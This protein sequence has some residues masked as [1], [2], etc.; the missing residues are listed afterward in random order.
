[1]RGRQRE[2]QGWKRSTP[3]QILY[4]GLRPACCIAPVDD[5]AALMKLCA[6]LTHG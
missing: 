5:D 4:S 1:M 6:P 2:H 3:V